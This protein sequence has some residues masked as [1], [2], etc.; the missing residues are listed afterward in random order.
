MAFSVPQF[1]L[2]CDI[3]TTTGSSKTFRLTSECNL[4]LGRREISY[5]GTVVPSSGPSSLFSPYVQ[6]LLPA[7]TDIRDVACGGFNDIVEVPAE[8]GRWYVVG[9]VDDFG[10]GFP[11]EHRIALLGKIWGFPPNNWDLPAGWP[12]PIP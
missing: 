12:I 9:G 8:S 10:K 1:P 4:A 6:L 5:Q 2:E 3:Y 11:N 7:G